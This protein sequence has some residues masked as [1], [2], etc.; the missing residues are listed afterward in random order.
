MFSDAEYV[1]A[2][3]SLWPGTAHTLS[4]VDC[5]LKNVSPSFDSVSSSYYFICMNNETVYLCE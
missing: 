1:Y 3:T 2:V 5:I 4:S